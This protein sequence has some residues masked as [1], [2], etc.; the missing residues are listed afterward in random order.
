MSSERTFGA[1]TMIE[2]LRRV[3]VKQPVETERDERKWKSYLYF[4]Q[5]SPRKTLKEWE[6][7]VALLKDEVDEVLFTVKK[8]KGSLDSVFVQDPAIILD[9]GALLCKMA[10]KVRRSEVKA[11][12]EDLKAIHI[13]IKWRISGRGTVEGGDCLWLDRHNLAVGSAYRTNLA[14]VKQLQ[15]LLEDIATIHLVHLPHWEGPSTCFHLQSLITMVDRKMALA[16]TKMLPVVF[17][18]LLN[19]LG[20]DIIEVVP[21][22][23]DGM[24]PN[25]LAL[26]PGR[27]MMLAGYP[28]TRGRLIKAG[29]D[30]I[31]FKAPELCN[32]RTGGA[33]CLVRPILRDRPR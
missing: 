7:F 14:G 11:A 19:D 17:L 5:P 2:R 1:Q 29:I 16:H 22:E 4:H 12:V 3:Q 25:V 6:E 24:T 8:Q 9:D 31:T 28:K 26:R 21:E 20:I 33:T 30:V 27:V 18:Q 13:P 10:K 32:N 15:D 23:F